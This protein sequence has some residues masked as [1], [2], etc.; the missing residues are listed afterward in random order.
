MDSDRTMQAQESLPFGGGGELPWNIHSQRKE[1]AS[2]YIAM[3]YLVILRVHGNQ[4]QLHGNTNKHC[5][6]CHND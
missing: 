3:W 4:I 1:L 5:N 2:N 6:E